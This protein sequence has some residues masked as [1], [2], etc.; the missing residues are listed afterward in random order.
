MSNNFFRRL[1]SFFSAASSGQTQ[2]RVRFA[3]QPDVKE[4]IDEGKRLWNLSRKY[5]KLEAVD[6]LTYLLTGLIV[7]GV[8]LVVLAIALFC[9]SMLCVS[10]LKEHTGNAALS[11]GLV[12]GAL[13]IVALLFWLLRRTLVQR[14]CCARSCAKFFETNTLEQED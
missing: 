10:L 5:A 2:E 7:G 14:R 11:Y 6:K 12:G 13:I 4:T 3:D 1:S 8:L 9:F